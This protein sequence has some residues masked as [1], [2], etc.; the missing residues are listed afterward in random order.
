MQITKKFLSLLL[1]CVMLLSMLPATAFASEGEYVY[2]SISFDGQY[3]DD[4]NGN[5]VAY[6]AVPLDSIAAVDLSA[7]GLDNM[8]F[9]A[10]GDGNYEITALQLLIYAHEEIY[11]GSWSDVNFDALPG[12][13]YF[14]GGIFGF[15]E[16][17]VYFHNGDFPVDASQDSSYMTVGATSDR[18]VL[19]AGDFLDVASFS[20]YGFLWDSNGGFHM[21]ADETGSY[22]HDYNVKVGEALDVKLMHSFCDLMYG[23]A[24]VADAMDY[25][26]YYGTTFGEALGSVVTDGSGC[27]QIVL[28]D[29]GTYYVWCDGGNSEDYGLHGGCDY[30][31]ETGIPCVVSA[32]AY[33]RVTV[34]APAHTHTVQTVPGKPATCEDI[35]LTEGEKCA[36]C[37][38]I[39]KVQE[40]IPAAGHAW[41]AGIYTGPTYEADGFTTYTCS[42]CGKT[43]V[44]VEEGSMLTTGCI[45]GQPQSVTVDSGE[46]VRFSVAAEGDVVSYKWEYRKIYKWFDTSMEG[47]D[48]DTLTIPAVGYRNGYD[49]RCLITFA[50]G[51]QTYSEPAELT[52]KTQITNVK[53]P[54]DQTVVLGYRCQFSAEAQG[55]SVKY[56]WYYKRPNSTQWWETSM[57]GCTQATVM[58]ET[59]T[60]RDGYQY[61][62]KITDV[63][64]VE[65]YTEPATMRVLSFKTYPADVVAAAGDKAVFTVATSVADGFTYQWQYS[66]DG[67]SWFNT[68]MAG[69]NT[70]TL[71]VSATKARDGYQYRCVLTGS[72]NS[73]I[74]SKTAILHVS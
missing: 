73:K 45:T 31:L 10:D 46:T 19:E 53:S 72:K 15:T 55:E 1:A 39:L 5:A 69:Y 37:G 61:R 34:A 71:T 30:C 47:F 67:E 44:V 36:E 29:A 32:P 70:D 64:G 60:D 27:A 6:M 56:Q 66:R 42:A 43:K 12:S 68:T 8:W 23:Q 35:G 63:T 48:T 28:P 24:W 50:D 54:N 52:V 51:T 9:D 49:Y 57:E 4:K 33:A 38:E 59:T 3:I 41:D 13:S 20:C 74:E 58:I 22:V 62:C 16:N 25:E 17:L 11:G 65:V 40:E 26:V 18:I 2:I 7:Y 21:F 14:A